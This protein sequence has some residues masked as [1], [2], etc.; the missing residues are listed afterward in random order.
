[1][2]SADEVKESLESFAQSCNE[3]ERLKVMNRDWNRTIHIHATDADA[4]F[5]LVSNEGTV[6][7]M[8]GAPAA[9]DM[10]AAATAEILS[11]VFYG[12][13]SPNVPYNDGTLRVQGS[14]NDILRLDF[15]TAM[16]WE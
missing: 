12:E 11:Q 14:E 3:N 1:M 15:I 7:T 9:A 16:L 6:T 2:A 8:T 5:T 10:L 4:H 13:V